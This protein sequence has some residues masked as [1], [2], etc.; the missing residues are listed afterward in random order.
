MSN[1]G[2][3][4]II[5]NEDE[6]SHIKEI[7][8]I[9]LNII[10]FHRFLGNNDY[11]DV[12]S[13]INK[14]SYV[15]LKNEKLSHEINDIITQ[16]ENNFKNNF[17]EYAQQLILSFYNKNEAKKEG[18]TPWEIW[19]F[20]LILSKNEEGANNEN[21][22]NEEEKEN[23]IREYIFNVIEKLNDKED[24]MPNVDLD[25][26]SLNEETFSY[27]FKINKIMSKEIYFSIFDH[28][29][30]KISQILLLLI[31]YHKQ[32]YIIIISF[33]NIYFFNKTHI[34]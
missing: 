34:K 2:E 19:N 22:I 25:N 18:K 9:S 20:I 32:L 27:D 4:A 13:E 8:E 23:K 12:Q 21:K 5:S 24:Y 10:F 1:Y 15:K 14:I 11:E 30:K 31:I 17:N 26:K 29:I 16:I 33:I 7:M 6:I 3:Y 28:F